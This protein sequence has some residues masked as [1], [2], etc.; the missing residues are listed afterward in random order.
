MEAGGQGCCCP[1]PTLSGL[2]V[3]PSGELIPPVVLQGQARQSKDREPFGQVVRRSSSGAVSRLY[4]AVNTSARLDLL[5]T[6]RGLHL[7]RD[8][9]WA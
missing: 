7:D 2:T 3:T 1:W 4:F 9:A 6:R 5:R 8:Q